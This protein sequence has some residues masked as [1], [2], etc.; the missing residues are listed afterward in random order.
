MTAELNCWGLMGPPVRWR[1]RIREQKQVR[2]E[3]DELGSGHL[4]S[5]YAPED[6]NDLA[7]EIFETVTSTKTQ[8][9]S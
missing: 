1:H 3:H 8:L 2:V 7:A 5:R 6:T 4:G 9:F